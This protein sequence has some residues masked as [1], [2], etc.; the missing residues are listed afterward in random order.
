[1][2]EHMGEL[3]VAPAPPGFENWHEL[4]GLLH[5]CFAYMA[6]RIDPPSS[7]NRMTSDDLRRKSEAETLVL[8]YDA[9]RLVGCAYL[10]DRPDA[11][12]IGKVAV[13]PEHQRRG[14][15]RRMMAIAER[16]AHDC[17]K[18]ALELETRIE[19]AENHA[20]FRALGFAKS[21]EKA[22]AGYDRPT[23]ITMRKPL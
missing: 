9:G 21:A 3:T 20:T 11:I 16:L 19:L 1:M 14:I 7:L 15:L 10:A 8:A 13:L 22:H 5:T 4:H 18:R 2:G 6:D 17:G 12:Y 23:S